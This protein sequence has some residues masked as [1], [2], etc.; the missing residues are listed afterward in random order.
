MDPSPPVNPDPRRSLPPVDQLGR[1]VAGKDPQ[2]PKWA[3]K[4]GSKRALA[5]FRAAL[6]GKAITGPAGTETP[7]AAEATSDR[8]LES[9]TRYA[10]RLA[11][12]HP[13]PVVNATGVVL[14][15]N[16]GRAPLAEGAAQAAAEAA[17]RYSDLELD[18]ATG[19]RGNRLASLSEKLC[20][21]SGA[22]AAHACNNNAAALLL[23]LDTLARGR[24]VIVSRG[25]LVEIGG[26]FRVPDIMERSGVRLVE[27]GTT[28][29]THPEDY[30]N[31]I[32]PDTALLLKV[33]RSNFKQIGFV[34][35][36]DLPTLSAIGRERGL[37]VV[38]DLGSGSLLDLTERG[39]PADS[40]AP[41]RLGMGADLVCFSGDKL[42]GGPQ[43]GILLG[44]ESEIEAVRRNPLARAL[45]LDKMSLAALEWTLEA[46]L[47]HR[48]ESEIP[49]VGR[50]LESA[51]SLEARAHALAE[52]LGRRV[53]SRVQIAVARDRTEVGGGSLPG[54]EL[55]T[56]VVQ[57]VAEG[58]AER[59][60]ATLRR[61]AVPVL[62]RIRDGA[63]LLDLRTL[64]EGDCARVQEAVA[65]AL[66]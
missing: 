50:L 48:A 56:W 64:D 40:Y 32:G 35:E 43:A 21:L 11:A 38:E 10:T 27:V 39:F 53:G 5:E 51:Q 33:H 14:H 30:E 9:A 8:L 12:R 4:E 57:L 41:A 63:V 2:L 61:G 24:E 66:V 25:E 42:L 46:M 44:A 28:N 29:R 20:L 49:V 26:S 19:Q 16:L 23:V 18:L 36:V 7:D 65:A 45:R 13:R 37:R 34:S 54:F 1:E 47:D 62:A 15:T 6:A 3:V 55:E 52:G 59:L 22:P 17:A 60:A 58:G 31:A